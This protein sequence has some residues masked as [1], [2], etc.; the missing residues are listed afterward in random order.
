MINITYNYNLILYK[1]AFLNFEAVR[2][3]EQSYPSD[4]S[5]SHET[6]QCK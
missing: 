4:G 6:Y 5:P 1:D 3:L 2:A